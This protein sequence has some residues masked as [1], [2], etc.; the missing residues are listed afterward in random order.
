M[1]RTSAAEQEARRRWC[2]LQQRSILARAG[3]QGLSLWGSKC[4][5]EDEG[6]AEVPRVCFRLFGVSGASRA[7]VSSGLYLCGEYLLETKKFIEFRFQILFGP[8]PLQY[9]SVPMFFL[10]F[11]IIFCTFSKFLPWPESL[12]SNSVLNCGRAGSCLK[13]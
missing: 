12:K 8:W 11:F 7:V 13:V 3:L 9:S 1:V 6:C 10:N 5:K 2:E 4:W